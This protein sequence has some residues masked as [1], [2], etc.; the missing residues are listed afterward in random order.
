MQNFVLLFFKA[1]LLAHR[2]LHCFGWGET[3]VTSSVSQAGWMMVHDGKHL[4]LIILKDSSWLP[5]E[6]SWGHVD[7]CGHHGTTC[8]V[9]ENSVHFYIL[10]PLYHQHRLNSLKTRD[11][12]EPDP[13]NWFCQSVGQSGLC[14]DIIECPQK[15]SGS[16]YRRLWICR[17][18]ILPFSFHFLKVRVGLWRVVKQHPR[19]EMSALT[20][21]SSPFQSIKWRLIGIL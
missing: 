12:L 19:C 8:L 15:R 10:L 5:G 20:L 7:M 11:L 3:C 9:W 21:N 17:L 16:F 18:I 13:Q 1:M 6:A 2:T 4:S 14:S